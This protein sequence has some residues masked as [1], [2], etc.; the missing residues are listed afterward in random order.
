MT[1]R[2]HLWLIT[3]S[4]IFLLGCSQQDLVDDDTLSYTRSFSVLISSQLPCQLH[5]TQDSLS[6]P[7]VNRVLSVLE[8][9]IQEIEQHNLAQPAEKDTEFIN[10]LFF[11][12]DSRAEEIA[13]DLATL[14]SQPGVLP[15]PHLLE[16]R[17]VLF[18]GIEVP[19]ERMLFFNLPVNEALLRCRLLKMELTSWHCQNMLCRSMTRPE[20][21]LPPAAA[22]L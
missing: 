3:T 6:L 11:G 5:E 2:T 22:D 14:N 12:P 16:A 18:D 19:W 20:M 7:L 15:L 1:T 9:S 10:G 13:K 8:A 4:T 17:P 21:G